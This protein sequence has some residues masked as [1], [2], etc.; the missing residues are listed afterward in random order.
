MLGT[1]LLV[2]R[3]VFA[4]SRAHFSRVAVSGGSAANKCRRPKLALVAT[5]LLITVVGRKVNK[6]RFKIKKN[7]TN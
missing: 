4:L 7:S 5:I 2:C 1:I 3:A 6:E